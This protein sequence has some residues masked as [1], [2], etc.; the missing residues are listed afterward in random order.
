MRASLLLLV[1][2]AASL[3]GCRGPEGHDAD[4]TG[5]ASASPAPSSSPVRPVEGAPTPT[6]RRTWTFDQNP[7]GKPPTGFSFGRT[8][9]GRAGRWEVLADPAAP[10]SPNVLA[11]LDA[12]PTDD[13]FPVAAADA[14]ELRDLRLTVRCK[15]VSGE[16]DQAVGLVFRYRDENDYYLTRANAL[17][18]NVR[19]YFVKDGRRQQIATWN[20]TVASGAWHDYR[21][22]ARGDHFEV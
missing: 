20:G 16:V 13:R 7:T 2:S 18:S 22:E 3:T 4:R 6:V 14:P 21:I 11:Q 19:L 12:D 1:L 17:E 10:S 9:V 8:G 5:A 15:P